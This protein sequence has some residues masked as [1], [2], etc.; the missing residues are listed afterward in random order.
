MLVGQQ[1]RVRS[2]I[3]ASLQ[4]L[5][6][7]VTMQLC[8]SPPSFP[9]RCIP[10]AEYLGSWAICVDRE[11]SGIDAAAPNA[12]PAI[13]QGDSRMAVASAALII[14]VA[15]LFRYEYRLFKIVQLASRPAK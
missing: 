7:P 11:N 8:L 10:E 14:V 15:R 4:S 12:A 13:T 3:A 2:D 6:K 5:N 1:S 9:H